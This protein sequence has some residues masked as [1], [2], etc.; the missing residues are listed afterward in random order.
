M[1]EKLTYI[2]WLGRL[3]D[4]TIVPNEKLARLA[5]E[6]KEDADEIERLRE[7]LD[8]ALQCWD[9]HMKH[10]FAMQGDWVQSARTALGEDK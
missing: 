7:A 3:G 4:C 10:G 2:Q 6:R 5:E 1:N 8:W 9:E